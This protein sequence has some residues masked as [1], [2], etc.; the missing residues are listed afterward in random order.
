VK[1]HLAQRITQAEFAELVGLSEAR[2]SQLFSEGILD[3]GGVAIDWIRAYVERLRNMAVE[4]GS[5]GEL[6][7]AQER[8]ALTREQRIGV[9]MKNDV[10]RTEFAPTPVLQHV[11]CL[12]S[13][14]I[15]SKLDT[16]PAR[17]KAAAP[18]L[19]ESALAAISTEVARARDDWLADTSKLEPRR[20][21][22]LAPDDDEDEFLAALDGDTTLPD[23]SS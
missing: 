11:L 23:R 4:R 21:P 9:A 6:D 7:L 18:E 3:R 14:S 13:E 20:D 19:S 22:G 5:H 1:L 12:A 15:A 17:L 8:A 2:V 10:S 16:L